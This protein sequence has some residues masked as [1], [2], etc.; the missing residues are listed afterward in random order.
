MYPETQVAVGKSSI[1]LQFLDN[2]FK[3]HHDATIG[4]EFGSK[5]VEVKHKTIKLQIWD[6]A[7]Q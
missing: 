7:G 4:V 5:F 1:V 6:T 2:K 3:P